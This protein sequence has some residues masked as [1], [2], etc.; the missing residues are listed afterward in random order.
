MEST[1]KFIGALVVESRILLS[2]ATF[3]T[4]H[5]SKVMR[6]FIGIFCSKHLRDQKVGRERKK[7]KRED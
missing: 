1:L 4:L 7:I 6:L 3:N 2:L 5:L